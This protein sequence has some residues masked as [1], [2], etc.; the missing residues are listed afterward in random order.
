MDIEGLSFVE[1][2]RLLAPKAGVIL[3]EKSLPE[4]S[5]RNRVL[6]CLETATDYYH[7][8]LLQADQIKKYLIDRDLDEKSVRAWRIGYSPESWDDLLVY[9]R[10]KG[11]KNEE[12]FAAGLSIKKEGNK[13]Y[14]RF[15]NRIMFPISNPNGLVVGFSARI[16]PED[17]ND[18]QGK[19]VNSPQTLVYDKSRIL[20][21]LDK[22]K[23]T[24]RTEDLAIIVEGQL[25]AITAHKHG[26][27]NVVASSGTALTSEQV[28]LIKRYT[29]NIAFAFDMDKAG[30]MAADRGVRE[31]ALEDMNMK[32]IIIASGKDP[33]EC[34]R[35]NPEEW[36]RAIKES[37]DVM[38][39]FFDKIILETD[40][41]DG[42]KRK[43]ALVDILQRLVAV[44]A[45][46]R[47]EEDFWLKRISQKIKVDEAL[48]RKQAES[49][50]KPETFRE[51]TKEI[52]EEPKP[53]RPEVLSAVLLSLLIRFPNLT[54]YII[55]QTELDFLVNSELIEFYKT[56]IIYYNRIGSIEYSELKQYL[57]TEHQGQVFLLDKLSLQGDRD[58]YD[59]SIDQAKTEVIKTIR[60]LKLNSLQEKRRLLE[61]QIMK[62]EGK[63]NSQVLDKLMLDFQNLN[64]QILES[65][66]TN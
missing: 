54:P 55:G 48:I 57:Q 35:N 49:L 38:Q 14:N 3:E 42:A 66:E 45:G 23:G 16:N 41:E 6:D 39:Y 37:K 43:K 64:R 26:Y 2:L 32:V 47:V 7:R 19:Y 50:K 56:L 27:T 65:E 30:Q 29:K 53:N 12:I 20:F 51:E 15:R 34:L 13:Y 5:K 59:F 1:T 22:A 28:K 44:T 9:L 61:A 63:D 25:D 33:D 62:E 24:I 4:T 21:G 58:F 18:Q 36:E 11:Y 31:A 8:K 60:E 10:G 52:E 40:L 46:N 17:K